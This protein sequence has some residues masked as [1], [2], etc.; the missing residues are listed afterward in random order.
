MAADDGLDL[1]IEEDDLDL[2]FRDDAFAPKAEG[3]F[4]RLFTGPRVG[5]VVRVVGAILLVLLVISLLWRNWPPVR[6]HFVFWK[7]DI[8]G[9]ILYLL[10][11]AL[12]VLLHWLWV[13]HRTSG[14]EELEPDELDEDLFAEPE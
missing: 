10:F 12:G 2:D 7:W 8:P 4:S 13:R 11:A 3:W 9:V 6:L 14:A 1:E 5:H